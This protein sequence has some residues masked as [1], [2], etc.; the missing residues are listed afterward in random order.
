MADLSPPYQST[1][2][3]VLHLRG[4][5][6]EIG[7]QHGEAVGG[8]AKEGML[9]F[10]HA[11]WTR[12][13]EA[14]PG[15]R[16]QKWAWAAGQWAMSA[17]VLKKLRRQLP[18]FMLESI[19]GM[20]KATGLDPEQLILQTLLPD[21]G[22][23]TQAL[24]TRLNPRL[25]MPVQMPTFGC[26]SFLFRGD[27]FLHGRNLD[28]PGVGYWDRFP[29]IQCVERPGFLRYIGFTSAGVPVSGITGV[30]EAQI[31][32]S[33]HQHYCEETNLGGLLPF[34]L[35]EEILSR[36]RSLEEAV[37]I[38]QSSRVATAWA[39]ILTDGKTREGM[40]YECHPRAHG[41]RRLTPARNHLAHSN[42]FQTAECQPR[43]YAATARMNWDNRARAYRLEHNL[44][45][46]SGK[47]SSERAVQIISEH[48]DPY[49]KSDKV[50]NRTVSQIYNIQSLILD[51]EN[52]KVLIAEG[53]APVH[54]GQYHEWDLGE[55]FAGKEGRTTNTLPGYQFKDP[56]Q[57]QAKHYYIWSFIRAMDGDYEGAQ[58]WL[59]R[60]LGTHFFAE[61]ALTA[62]VIDMKKKQYA[63]AHKK[64]EKAR[65]EIEGDLKPG[66]QAPPEYFEVLFFQARAH[67][68]AGERDKALSLY[69]FL[70]QHRDLEDNN[71]R[72]QCLSEK[73]YTEKKLDRIMMPY[74]SY[75]PY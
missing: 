70:A 19:Q 45:A 4:E 23:Y 42:F 61:G 18:P 65:L 28:F 9:K 48:Y 10:Y 59:E 33:L 14:P 12:L 50:F 75:L 57:N 15:P 56:R 47:L 21:V 3:R 27:R 67:D 52:M 26:S 11:F 31:S 53:T 51:T 25:K 72:L 74:S 44:E 34:S 58:E 46:C 16:S 43:E 2:L 6:F 55:I 36:A 66:Q 39:F 62:A 32:V 54:L 40:I 24:A 49:W 64:L 71:M 22:P 60:A 35:G 38:L 63:E 7:R 37:A 1:P 41:I 5:P 29:V 8:D 73:P 30:N 20:A 17:F 69:R 68:L 13:T